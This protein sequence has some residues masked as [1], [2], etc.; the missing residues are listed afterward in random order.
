MNIVISNKSKIGIGRVV[1]SKN[2]P[3]TKVNFSRV[4]HLKNFPV[5]GLTDVNDSAKTDNAVL[6]YSVNTNSY[7]IETLPS[8]DGGIY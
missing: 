8:I 7:F 2:N 3:I 4:A 1:V 5:A 6:V